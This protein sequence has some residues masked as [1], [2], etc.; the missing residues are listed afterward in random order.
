MT[1]ID[2]NLPKMYIFGLI[3][4]WGLSVTVHQQVYPNGANIATPL[5]SSLT[6]SNPQEPWLSGWADSDGYTN[7]NWI[8]SGTQEYI[9]SEVDNPY[10]EAFNDL[11]DEEEVY[12]TFL[13]G[14]WAPYNVVAAT[15]ANIF[16]PSTGI[17]YDFIPEFAPTRQGMQRLPQWNTP[18]AVTSVDVVFTSDR[19][20]WTRCPVLEMQP[21]V[22]LAE[23]ATG[24]TG[25]LDKMNPRRHESVDKYGRTAAEGGNAGEANLVSGVGMGWFPGYAID[26]TTGERLNMAFG[27]DSWLSA[28]N[29]KD[30]LWNPSSNRQYAGGQH[31]IYVFR[32]GQ[33]A[34]GTN[35]RMPAYD[36]GAFL[37]SQLSNP[38]A[39]SERLAFRDCV[40]VG[41][42]ISND[43]Y[44]MKSIEDGLIPNETRV[45]LRVARGY[46]KYSAITNDTDDIEQAV[47]NWDPIYRFD[48]EDVA[49]QLGEITVLE[50]MLEEINIVPNPYYAYSQ[51]ETNKL[52]NRVKIVNLPEVCTVRIY[53][54][55]G[56]LVRT[57]DK[58]DPLTYVDWDLKNEANVP[59][60]GGVYII[61]ID[62]PNVGQAVRKWFGVMRPV[63]LDNF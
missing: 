24:V 62:V 19:S 57:Y 44:P 4:D 25:N 9:N 5:N 31:W 20:K 36:A 54:L 29:G 22:L 37:M 3:L 28:D 39:T 55:S 1:K 8:R 53:N 35:N 15:D 48:T 18:E 16:D 21:N 33:A 52:D 30:M 47:N 34:S 23:N 38:T 14:T 58:A 40:W 63:D 7:R 45:S 17:T 11:M 12:E 51:Y 6:F 56:T 59:I 61:H 26:L 13:G 42:A 49:T 50:E 27:E 46:D 32:N 2:Q 41:S 60:A 43:N 10:E